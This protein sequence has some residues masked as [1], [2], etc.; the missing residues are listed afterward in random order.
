MG[1]FNIQVDD[2]PTHQASQVGLIDPLSSSNL[3]L[4]LTHVLTP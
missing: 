4:I 3:V 1:D 2:L